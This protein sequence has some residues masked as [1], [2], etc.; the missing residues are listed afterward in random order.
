MLRLLALVSLTPF[1]M[2][3]DIVLGPDARIEKQKDGKFVI[4]ADPRNKL[5]YLINTE[6]LIYVKSSAS[7][8][9]NSYTELKFG[10]EDKDQDG[11]VIRIQQRSIP[12]ERIK[13]IILR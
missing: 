7:N 5:E 11:L 4:I 12:Y 6:K 3:E 8:D 13:E 1:L 2:A 10:S 9:N